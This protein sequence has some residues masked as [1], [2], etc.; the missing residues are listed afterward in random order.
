MTPE[1]LEISLRE[2][3]RLASI[4]DCILL[5]DEVDTFFSQR[6]RA[7]TAINKNAMVSGELSC[8]I[9]VLLFKH[10]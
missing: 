6:S 7:D 8:P 1:R 3:F 4:W 10:C 2:I 9:R 5:L